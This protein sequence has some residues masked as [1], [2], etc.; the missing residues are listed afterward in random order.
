MPC[1]HK[2]P[3]RC[4]DPCPKICLEIVD[5]V[6]LNCNHTYKIECHEKQ[7][8]CEILCL[9]KCT[10]TLVCGHPCAA[11]CYVPCS[12]AQCMTVVTK[13]LPCG[14]TL[15]R[16][17]YK[18]QAPDMYPC[19]KECLKKLICGHQCPAK[20]GEA[21]NPAQCTKVCSQMLLC[22]HVCPGIC[23]ECYSTR[24]HQACWADIKMT[25]FC[26]HTTFTACRGLEHQCKKEYIYSCPHEKYK[27]KCPVQL[28]RC[29]KPCIWE[30]LHHKCY[31]L[32][33]E[34][35][36][37]GPCG[38]QCPLLLKCGHQCS[39]LCGEPCLRACPKCQ[40]L[41][42]R[43]SLR[44]IEAKNGKLPPKQLYIQLQPCGHIFTVGYL[45][46][47]MKRKLDMICP[48][49]CPDPNCN[50]SICCGYRYGNAAKAALA[51]FAMVSKTIATNHMKYKTMENQVVTKLDISMKNCAVLAGCDLI[52]YLSEIESELASE[53]SEVC[54]NFIRLCK[55]PNTQRILMSDQL[56]QDFT[57]EVFRIFLA[58]LLHKASRS[59]TSS[60]D[61]RME[62]VIK[63]TE[64]YLKAL[65][66][67]HFQ[68]ISY[69]DFEKHRRDICQL[70]NPFHAPEIDLGKEAVMNTRCGFG[71][72]F[73]WS[74]DCDQT[75][76]VCKCVASDCPSVGAMTVT[77]P[78]LC[79]N[80]RVFRLEVWLLT[81]LLLEQ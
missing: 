72:P 47:F 17:C 65:D 25:P 26:G 77:K 27:L 54:S 22:G 48:K 43:R 7:S 14:H 61:R 57:S 66:L 78:T 38:I 49:Q 2:C 55:T 36:D 24:M 21:C 29:S 31:K 68:R 67:D 34:Q 8:N 80:V 1:G 75:H 59:H 18:F 79:A 58:T 45:D 16:E 50:V 6:Q 28:P 32:C 64:D 10:K 4:K 56:E 42:F 20:C 62:L 51:D 70:L 44:G 53:F 63:R 11:K 30:C 12:S 9:Q 60:S 23:G 52:T 69:Q 76:S 74:N 41:A 73:C 71:L 3:S 40:D 39:S 81:A 46:N 33:Y 19:D 35:C 37:R 13:K 5:E 15:M